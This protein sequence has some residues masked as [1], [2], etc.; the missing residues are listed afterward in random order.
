[1]KISN[2]VIKNYRNIKDINISLNDN[3]VLIG[4]N[5]SGKSNFLKALTLPLIN[6]ETGYVNKLLNWQDIN[7]EAK[8]DYFNFLKKNKSEIISGNIEVDKF[9][10]IIPNVQVIL[11]FEISNSEE[12][13]FVR[14]WLKEIDE[15]NIVA[16]I[17]YEFMVD[18]PKELFE[19]VAEVLEKNDEIN[20]I[21]MNL[22]P[23]EYYS[24][25]IINPLKDDNVSLSD[26]SYFK[27]NSV[28][29]ERD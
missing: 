15:E 3:V 16:S 2:V 6:H 14:N 4:D 1:M 7:K 28:A 22:L 13:Y 11:D 21:K 27:Y 17:K 23:L 18:N 8:E 29:A 26:L 9:K 20:I 12:I 24:Y 5:N 10:D 25:K 19:Y